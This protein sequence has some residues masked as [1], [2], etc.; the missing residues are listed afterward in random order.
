MWTYHF[1]FFLHNRIVTNCVNSL[2]FIIFFLYRI[3]LSQKLAKRDLNLVCLMLWIWWDVAMWYFM[4]TW[5]YLI[6]SN[7]Q[8]TGPK[9]NP[10]HKFSKSSKNHRHTQYKKSIG[11]PICKEHNLTT[12]KNSKITLKN[13]SFY[14]S[15]ERRVGKECVP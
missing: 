11:G 12:N 13:Y 1:F 9:L 15:E 6:G 4:D 10:Q 3:E 2:F 14:R 5:Q 8:D 7:A